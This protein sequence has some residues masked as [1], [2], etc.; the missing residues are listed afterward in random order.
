MRGQRL[1]SPPGTTHSDKERS[2]IKKSTREFRHRDRIRHG[3]DDGCGKHA[4][5]PRRAVGATSSMSVATFTAYFDASGT[6]RM[7]AMAFAGFVSGVKKWDRWK[8]QWEEILASE[9]VSAF[10]MTD[11]AGSEGEYKL[12]KGDTK[13][14]RRFISEL[15]R[16]I[17]KNTNKGFSSGLYVT[18]YKEVNA[19]F[20]LDEYVGKPY[21][22]CGWACLG[23]LEKWMMKKSV[24]KWA[25]LIA[26]EEG[27]EDQNEL[28]ELARSRSFKIVPR[29]KAEV[30]AFEA[31]DLVGWKN[32]IVLQ[33]SLKIRLGTK[34]EADAILKSLD[35]LEGVVHSN[36]GFD[37]QSLRSLCVA[38]RIPR[39]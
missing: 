26:I 32:R 28:M 25:V 3:D 6:K 19:D 15:V 30:R 35:P 16:C 31:A 12:W 29:S 10:H 33:E 36:K 23:A 20:R 7:K 13:R 22:L 4:D 8:V 1:L 21:T 2:I 37:T 5:S 14:R 11:F 24:K 9:G 27:D 39:R 17:K 34:E 38:H 18:D